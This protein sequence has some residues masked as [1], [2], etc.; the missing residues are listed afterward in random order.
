[1]PRKIPPALGAT[2]RFLRFSRGWTGG[3]L[4]QAVEVSPPLLSD[5]EKGVKTLS[6][7][8]LEGLVAPMNVPPEAIDAALLALELLDPDL[9]VPPNPGDLTPEERRRIV[10]AAA[11]IGAGV[12]R[13]IRA[14][15]TAAVRAGRLEEDRRRAR[16]VWDVLR[17]LSPK[18]RRTVV[19]VAGEHLG[20]AVCERL[21][22]ESAKA[23][24]DKAERAVELAELALRV[25]ERTPGA[26]STEL[27][28]YAWAF[29]GNARRIQGNLP[30][31]DEAFRR[32]SDLWQKEAGKAVAGSTP[33]DRSRILNL[34]AS[35]RL[36]QGHFEEAITLLDQALTLSRTGEARVRLLIQRAVALG[37][38]ADHKGSI[39]TLNEAARLLNKESPIRLTFAVRFNL[40]AN[41]SLANRYAEASALLPNIRELAVS[42]GQELDLLRV[43]WLES[44][45]LAGLGQREQAIA[46]L[47]QVRGEFTAMEIAYDAALVSLETSV[48]LLEEGRTRE[49]KEMADQMLWIFRAQGVPR[50]ALAA[51]RLF[52]EAAEHET[53]TVE[54]TR[55]VLG[56]LEK[57]RYAP[58][59]RFEE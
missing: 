46:A 58:S 4:A 7:E 15:L 25:A 11:R 50:E 28:G 31:A 14:G 16:E 22:E 42:L 49:V 51:L 48:L 13:E 57:A 43:L 59:L 23:G 27:Q 53:A 5:Y 9:E 33:L 40:A 6:R 18:E 29:V 44:R 24:A 55:R 26:E 35:L 45:T 52:H 21:C 30:S 36:Y 47:E 54:M 10:R 41:L 56:Y 32:S 34:E 12:V 19:D 17:Q 1:M 38:V 3:D 20:W 37:I 2:L 39:E 8:R